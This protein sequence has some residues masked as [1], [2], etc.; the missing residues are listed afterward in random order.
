M[1][2]IQRTESFIFTSAKWNLIVVTMLITFVKTG[3]WYIPNL[4]K[5]LAIAQNPFANPFSDKYLHTLYW[6]WLGPFLAYL[7]GAKSVWSFF[8]LHLLFS[9]GFTV[10]L[11]STLFRRLPDRAARV[12]LI[13]FSVL[14]VSATAY[15]WV[16]PDS[17]TLFL[18]VC[19]LALP[20]RRTVV[21]L[22]GMA[23]GMQHFEQ[24]IV[25]FSGLFFALLISKWHDNRTEYSLGWVLNLLA[26]ITVGKLMLVAMFYSLDAEVSYD[27][28]E[29]LIEHHE[30]LLGYFLLHF[31]YII[32]SS[33]GLGWI[34]LIKYVDGRPTNKCLLVPLFLLMILL[35]MSLDQTRVYAIVSFPLVCVF[36]LFDGDLSDRLSNRFISW[37]FLSWLIIPLGWV[38]AGEPKWSV[39]SYD[40]A[41]LLN[42][43]LGWF[44]VPPNPALW[45]FSAR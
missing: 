31:N 45:P 7:I 4:D 26:G 22:F 43:L 40:I 24:A 8:V 3:I 18:M 37:I 21:P 5:S 42:R 6:N 39:F 9:A 23:L 19:A 29:W 36:W 11:V 25:G 16:G 14:P 35:P 27:R 20:E 13:V 15:F 32:W 12:S 41:Y 1:Q 28:F 44:P 34:I 30:I 10:L 38:W 17:L 33:L 2:I